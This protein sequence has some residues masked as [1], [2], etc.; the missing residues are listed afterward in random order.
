MFD[1]PKAMRLHIGIFGN[2][3][4]GKSSL[5][6]V[7]THQ[8]I[9]IV[10]EVPG[11]TADTVEKAMELLPLGPVVFI[12]TAGIDDEGELGGKRVQKTMK[13]VDKT[14]VAIIVSDYKGWD[15]GI[16][17]FAKKLQ[18]KKVPIISVINKCDK[19]LPSD[20]AIAEIRKFTEFI[21]KTSLLND[22]DF[23]VKIK[24]ALLKT[25]PEEFVKTPMFTEGLINPGEVAILVMPQD[26]AAP[27]GRLILPEVTV[28]RE[29]LDRRCITLAITENE[30][31]KTLE[32]LKTPPAIVITDSQVFS[33]V[34]EIVPET[35][36]LTSF[37]IIFAGIKGDLKEFVRGAEATTKLKDGDKILIC[38]SCTHH[39]VD[40]DIAKVKIPALVKKK[41]GKNLIFE[42]VSST[43]F[44]KNIEQYSLIIH[45]GGCMTNRREILSRIEKSKAA[46]V[47]ITN[48]GVEIACCTGILERTA[49]PFDFC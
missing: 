15:E 37:S 48:F 12:D 45:C 28:L 19:G 29:L 33:K 36:P 43:D 22:K 5:I 34:A 4:A 39:A 17:E 14:D 24:D 13:A 16:V 47:P 32:I 1:T 26:K 46:N 6:N 23:I 21:L 27:K 38:E 41:T 10:S 9:S 2:R 18:E 49:K 3:N 35:I 7:L 31:Q 20:A 11:T 8:E 40:D 42:F 25:V 44:P 30:L